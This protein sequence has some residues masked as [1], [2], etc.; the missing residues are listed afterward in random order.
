MV[1]EESRQDDL[2]EVCESLAEHFEKCEDFERAAKY[3]KMA[4]AKATNSGALTESVEYARRTVNCLERLPK[5][6]EVLTKIIDIRTILGIRLMDLNYFHQSKEM[7]SP[8]IETA[9]EM[10]RTRRI[11]Q[12]HTIL[13]SYYFCVKE[14][15]NQAFDHHYRSLNIIGGSKILHMNIVTRQWN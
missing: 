3:S 1:I 15:F 5:S 4:G 9:T 10:V 7:V 12:I 14:D 13:G 8:V 11:A 2:D 6:E